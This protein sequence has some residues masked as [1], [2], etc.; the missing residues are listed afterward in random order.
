MK[1][2]LQFPMRISGLNLNNRQTR[3]YIINPLATCPSFV[4]LSSCESQR[5]IGNK[6]RNERTWKGGKS[7]LSPQAQAPPAC[8]V[9]GVAVAMNERTHL[10]LSLMSLLVEGGFVVGDIVAEKRGV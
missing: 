2:F 8:A 7:K 4:I 3:T 9:W 10:N 1:S 5:Q 6:G